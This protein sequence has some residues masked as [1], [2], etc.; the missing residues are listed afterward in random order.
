M[1]L[2]FRTMLG[3][4]AVGVADAVQEAGAGGVELAHLLFVMSATTKSNSNPMHWT[5]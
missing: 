3:L 4:V 2:G 5:D 1:P